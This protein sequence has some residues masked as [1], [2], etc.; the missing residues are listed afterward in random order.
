ML[1]AVGL[2]EAAIIDAIV[3]GGLLVPSETEDELLSTGVYVCHAQKRELAPTDAIISLTFPSQTIFFSVVDL[4]FNLRSL[5]C[6]AS[7]PETTHAQVPIPEA[8]SAPELYSGRVR[9][10]KLP[11]HL[12]LVSIACLLWVKSL[13]LILIAWFIPPKR[14]Y[15]FA[16]HHR[17]SNRKPLIFNGSYC[18]LQHEIINIESA[19]NGSANSAEANSAKAFPRWRTPLLLINNVLRLAP[20]GRRSARICVPEWRILPL[21]FAGALRHLGETIGSNPC[22]MLNV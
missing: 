16:L 1:E 10:E 11:T 13:R 20:L 22:S 19:E 9:S 3:A 7:F 6:N 5:L 14:F 17:S 2:W 21:V 15:S 18:K 4:I 12:T 8:L